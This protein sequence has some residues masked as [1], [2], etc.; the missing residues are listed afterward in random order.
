MHS[1]GAV[2]RNK[3]SCSCAKQKGAGEW[4]QCLGL[5]RMEREKERAERAQQL[6]DALDESK[7]EEDFLSCEEDEEEDKEDDV[8]D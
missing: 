6:K 8:K 3:T 7:K 1:C 4:H 5:R 2:G